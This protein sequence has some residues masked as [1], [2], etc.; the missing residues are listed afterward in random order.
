MSGCNDSDNDISEGRSVAVF[1]RLKL[2]DQIGDGNGRCFQPLT[3]QADAFA[4]PGEVKNVDHFSS[5]RK[6]SAFRK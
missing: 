3:R 4:H 5:L 1:P 2:G 6:G